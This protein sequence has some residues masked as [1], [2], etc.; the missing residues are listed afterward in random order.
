MELS[1]SSEAEL[2]LDLHVNS[3]RKP[4]EILQ[5]IENLSKWSK[6]IR[7][8]LSRWEN[9]ATTRTVYSSLDSMLQDLALEQPPGQLAFGQARTITSD[10]FPTPV[11]NWLQHFLFPGV[12]VTNH[13]EVCHL[14]PKSPEITI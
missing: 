14:K 1:E 11:I 10:S 3:S 2:Q 6:R 7:Y 9:L 12:A 8:I 4:D 13:L 5:R